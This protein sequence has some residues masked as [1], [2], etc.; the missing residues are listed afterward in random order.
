MA[1]TRKATNGMI[2]RA[3]KRAAW[4]KAD[5]DRKQ[6]EAIAIYN[7]RLNEV[8]QYM[9]QREQQLERYRYEIEQR[10]ILAAEMQRARNQYGLGLPIN[11][12]TPFIKRP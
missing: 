1:I 6:Q 8:M 9:Q 4:R 12:L 5:D 10:R 7:Q 2:D 11:R 3:V